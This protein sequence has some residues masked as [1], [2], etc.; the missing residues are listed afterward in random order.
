MFCVVFLHMVHWYS[1]YR[2]NFTTF[3]LTGQA[4]FLFISSLPF[5]RIG[6]RRYYD[7]FDF[8]F[9]K[10]V[11]PVMN[12]LVKKWVY[13]T[14][15]H[16]N[17]PGRNLARFSKLETKCGQRGNVL[18]CAIHL[19]IISRRDSRKCLF[20]LHEKWEFQEPQEILITLK[21]KDGLPEIRQ[22]KYK[23]QLVLSIKTLFIQHGRFWPI[24]IQSL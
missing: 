1:T 8:E 10:N 14:P 20:R 9:T 12:R 21:R 4:N 22:S 17:L 15:G 18:L 5:S 16:G 13:H 6:W 11:S 24:S 2:D 7:C 23:F 19:S 3:H